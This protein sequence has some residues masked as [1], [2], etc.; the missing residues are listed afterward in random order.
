MPRLP[1]SGLDSLASPGTIAIPDNYQRT[2]ADPSAFGGD[3]KALQGFGQQL[4]QAGGTAMDIATQQQAFQNRGSVTDALTTA[5][6]SAMQV[7][8]GDPSNPA[9]GP[10]FYGLKGKQVLDRYGGAVGEV[11]DA[12]KT[13]RD[14]LTNDA[15]K[16]MFDQQAKRTQMSTLATMGQ[17]HASETRTYGIASQDAAV[18]SNMTAAGN[19]YTND[20]VF[21]DGIDSA[22]SHQRE[23][24]AMKGLPPAVSDLNAQRIVSEGWQARILRTAQDNPLAAKA[25]LDAN[26]G[27]LQPDAQTKLL[28]H[29]QPLVDKSVGQN[30][31]GGITGQGNGL[32][33]STTGGGMPG[34]TPAGPLPDMIKASASRQGFD[35]QDAL[36]V[37]KIESN[38][39][40]AADR[41]GS[42][43]QGPFQMG[44]AAWAARGG[45]AAN[46]NDPAAQVDLGIANLAH[47]RQVASTALGRPASGWETYLTHQQGDG[48]GPALLTAPAGQNAVAA[49][50]PAYGGS[51]AKATAAI[52][53]NGGR[54]DMTAGQFRDV[55]QAKFVAAGGNAGNP[56]QPV[57]TSKPY[58]VPTADELL[59]KADAA[60]SGMPLTVQDHVRSGVLAWRSQQEARLR[61][62]RTGF[63]REFGNTVAALQDGRDVSPVEEARISQLYPPEQ[64]DVLIEQ[65]RMAQTTGSISKAI[66]FAGPDDVAR[67][68]QDVNSGVGPISKLLAGRGGKPGAVDAT[69]PAQAE[70]GTANTDGYKLR[71]QAAGIIEQRIAA[72]QQ[73]MEADPAAYAAQNPALRDVIVAAS[74][75][76]ATPDQ[77]A[78]A[79][80]TLMSEQ[81]RLGVPADKRRALPV[82]Q[83][84]ADVQALTH[85]DPSKADMGLALGQKA[86]AYGDAW[87]EVFGSY[88]KAGLPAGFQALAIMD[89]PDQAAGRAEFQRALSLQAE[90]GG[91]AAL[92]ES[93]GKEAA[94][95]VDQGLDDRLADFK[96]SVIHARDGVR[97]FDTF[98]DSVKALAYYKSMQGN[99]NALE[100]AYQD[101]L[102][103][104]YDFDGTMRVPKGQLSDVKQATRQVMRTMVPGDLPAL[105]SGTAGLSEQDR[106]LK[107]W[108]SVQ[109]NGQWVPSPDDGGL[110]L[111][112]RGN[113]N[114]V[115][116]ITRADGKPV[117]VRFDRLHQFGP[118][119]PETAAVPTTA[120]MP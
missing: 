94:K 84:A 86:A 36:A 40:Q 68:R 57:D 73:Q 98:R 93:V 28:G 34:T 66:A 12:Y 65:Q 96:G 61:G 46:R 101:V 14:S 110:H 106:Q 56:V 62:D 51:T 103:K 16:L 21:Q 105:E 79:V 119:A 104:R 82:G 91:L 54:P 112:V 75:Q 92:R 44:N 48:G 88:V 63:T 37:A 117:E 31:L 72:R 23:A 4:Q 58:A 15:Q 10:G 30:I 70:D 77:R 18:Q 76:N 85:T 8:Y 27:R 114:Q 29:L 107:L 32:P 43:F 20:R 71:R 83:I 100:D 42:Q 47:S 115:I 11:E 22:I 59:A 6:Q 118:P 39:G 49:L 81:E 38:V 7:Q 120:F 108:N 109:S 60:T 13:A 67:M 33:G 19:G 35:P 41:P 24:D 99:G 74:A 17:H 9:A 69:M 45:T 25:M 87:P 64:A 78:A 95:T 53:G 111:I 2:Q 97:M 1:F 5:Q 116:P 89:K 80:H 50:A 90:K 102:G 113:N 55:W 52:V 26:L 3:T